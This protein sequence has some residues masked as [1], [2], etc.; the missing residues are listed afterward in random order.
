[1][2][3]Q[4]IFTAIEK[5]DPEIYERLDTRRSAMKRFANV[6]KALAMSAVPLALGSM[7]KKAYGRTPAD[8]LSVLQFA[9]LLEHLESG[10]YSEAITHTSL[11]DAAGFAAFT[12][13]ANQ[14]AAHVT[15]IAQT[16]QALGGTPD[17]A[18]AFTYTKNGALPTFTD[19]ATLLTVAQAFEDTGVRA[20]KGQICNL[21]ENRTVLTI[22][23][24][25]HS[26]EAR[27]AAHIRTMRGKKGWI[28]QAQNDF[29]DTDATYA[30]EDLT[31]QDGVTITGIC[32][33][34]TADAAT[35][36]FEEPLDAAT[37][38]TIIAPFINT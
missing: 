4:N 9:L 26:V 24:Q 37:V 6:G 3:L 18:P 31:V 19:L 7:F 36:A 8:V 23:L 33:G 14:E 15:L 21:Q 35:E 34:I 5:T 32:T 17:P 2:D 27:H 16:I 12:T 10:F 28:T 38:R 29:S 11:F 30:G 1:M 20:Y 25:I 22:A 13:I